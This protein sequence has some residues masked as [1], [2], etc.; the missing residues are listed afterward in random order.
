MTSTSMGRSP[1]SS[2]DWIEAR[3]APARFRVQTSAETIFTA[4]PV[5]A[6]GT[7]ELEEPAGVLPGVE[8]A[9]RLDP[10]H[11]AH[12]PALGRVGDQ[13]L[14]GVAQR[15]GV[16]GFDQEPVSVDDVRD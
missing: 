12:L 16:V 15:V 3:I 1:A 13:A 7:H 9:A 11:F 10:A 14:E 6:A 4:A 8:A 2:R 5:S